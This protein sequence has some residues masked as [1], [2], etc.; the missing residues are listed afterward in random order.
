MVRERRTLRASMMVR[1]RTHN[2][3]SRWYVVAIG[4]KERE[5]EE[6]EQ[7]EKRG[8]GDKEREGG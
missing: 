2:S 5:R 4:E 8:G 3:F 7:G 6:G 1:W